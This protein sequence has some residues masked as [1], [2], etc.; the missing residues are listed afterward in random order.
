M[1]DEQIIALYWRRSED[2]IKESNK[3]YGS[4]CHTVAQ[5]ILHNTEDADECVND[6]WL[7]A[8]TTIPPQRPAHL[9][10]FLARITRNL[11][12]DRY[13]ALSAIKRGG[14]EI[15]L[16]FDELEQCIE[17]KNEVDAALITKELGQSINRFVHT[18]PER[19]CSLFVRRYFFAEPIAKIAARYGLTVNNTTVILSRTR[20]KL[21]LYL[22]QEGF[23]P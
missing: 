18:L 21:K 22:K 17:G 5:N 11:A 6:T 13:K 15:D 4:Y 19:D 20:Q 10:L 12:F 2:A 3:K 9:Q 16:V 23:L 14:G 7:R 1:N 8:W